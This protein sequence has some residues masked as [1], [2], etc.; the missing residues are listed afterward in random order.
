MKTY[1]SSKNIF[2]V[3]LLWLIVFGIVSSFFI[4]EN[5]KGESIPIGIPIFL[6]LIGGF[7]IW[8][9][10]DTK[11]RI[12]DNNL[13]YYSG[14]IRGKIDIRQI[15]KI[16][17]VKTV[18]VSA[19]L[20]PALGSHGLMITYNKFDDIYISPKDKENFIA[21]LLKINPNIQIV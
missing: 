12:S 10:S 17:H 20:K 3:S 15:R 11:Y 7:L 21:E 5:E 14:P 2:F 18:F 4:P 9:L 8:T 1:Y 13:K 19:I 6:S 16:E